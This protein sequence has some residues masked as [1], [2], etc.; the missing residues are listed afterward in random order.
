MRHLVAH[1]PID[2]LKPTSDPTTELAQDCTA[3]RESQLKPAS[4]GD[5]SNL[6]PDRRFDCGRVPDC[7]GRS[8]GIGPKGKW[9]PANDLAIAAGHQL[10]VYGTKWLA[11]QALSS[12]MASIPTA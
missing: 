8:L 7:K 10:E 4:S 2:C 3:R 12:R 6:A 5:P 9:C 11:A 1:S